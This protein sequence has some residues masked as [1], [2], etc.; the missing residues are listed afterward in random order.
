LVWIGIQIE[1]DIL[2]NLS[3]TPVDIAKRIVNKCCACQSNRIMYADMPG[4]AKRINRHHRI[5]AACAYCHADR[6]RIS[7]EKIIAA[8]ITEIVNDRS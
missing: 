8:E 3:G 7:K 5:P 2:I 4:R 1:V 6:K